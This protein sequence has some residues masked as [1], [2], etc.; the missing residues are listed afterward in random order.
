MP[1]GTIDLSVM[2]G[3]A[4]HYRKEILSFEVVDFWGPYN[5]IFGRPCYAKFMA[6]PNYAY[7]KLKVTSSMRRQTTWTRRASSFPCSRPGKKL[8]LTTSEQQ[9]SV[10]LDPSSSTYHQL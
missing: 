5:A 1:Q 4:V 6:V 2:L 3:D 9:P 8:L 7:P 10:I